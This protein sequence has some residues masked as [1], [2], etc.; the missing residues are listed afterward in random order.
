MNN[1][2]I[3]K[4]NDSSQLLKNGDIVTGKIVKTGRSSVFIDLGALG[5]GIIFGKEFY[6]TKSKLKK[7]KIEDVITA[8]VLELDNEEGYIELSLKE[9]SKELNWKNLKEKKENNE[10]ITIKITNA[11]KG[12]LLAETT[13]IQMFLPVSQ[14]SSEHYPR[15]RGADKLKILEEL[16][17]LI[18]KELKVKIL[19]IDKQEEKVILSEKAKETEKI[20][21]VLK[22]YK[23]GDIIT[24]EISGIADFGAFIKFGEEN[25]EGFIHISELDWQLIKDPS[26]IVKIG[27]RIK[28]KIINITDEK[29]SLSL[30]ILKKNPWKEIEKKYKKG[31]II[32]G[33]VVKFN[34]F[35]AFIKISSKIQ[36]LVHISEFG[37]FENMEKTLKIDKKYKFKISVIEPKNYKITLRLTEQAK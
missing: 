4:S 19:D 37:S 34:S 15:I 14:L 26:E 9:A 36:G 23:K 20:K 33:T 16:K 25:L 28:A 12:G 1:L 32:T 5:T 6:E 10:I 27:Q 7:L 31:D 30:K 17:K 29:V 8:K 22:K 13:N 35:G 3:Q 24:G 21:E 11:N 2:N 18:G